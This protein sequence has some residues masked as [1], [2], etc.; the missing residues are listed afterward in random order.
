MASRRTSAPERGSVAVPDAAGDDSRTP[1][2]VAGQ[3]LLRRGGFPAVKLAALCELTGRT[4]GSF[5]HHFRGMSEFLGELASFF[6]TEQP[7][8]VLARLADRPPAERLSELERL[9][10]QLHMGTL[11][12]A[13]R[14]WATVNEPAAE[15]VRD[16]D[17]VVLEF[18][19]DTHVELGVDLEDAELRAEVIY[20]LAVARIDPPWPRR[21]TTIVRVLDAWPVPA[22]ATLGDRGGTNGRRRRSRTDTQQEEPS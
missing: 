15:A 17:R 6:G 19:R 3:E 11:H 12:R 16:A 1:W 13:M 9:S 8:A 14:D 20:A 22:D 10:V 5:Y 2:L 7:R 21:S 4:T 18:L